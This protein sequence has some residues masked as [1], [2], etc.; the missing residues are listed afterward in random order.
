MAI[1]KPVQNKFDCAPKIW[2]KFSEEQRKD[3]NNLFP[4]FRAEIRK[5]TELTLKIEV[6]SSDIVQSMAHNMAILAIWHYEK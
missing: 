2:S 6:L 4:E 5:L 3:F 1:K